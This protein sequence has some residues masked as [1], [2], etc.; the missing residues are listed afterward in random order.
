MTGF[1]AALVGELFTGKGAIG[2]LAL[3]TQLPPMMI[4][5]GTPDPV[6]T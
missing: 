2:Q 3:E 1:F 6:S 4:K 5:A